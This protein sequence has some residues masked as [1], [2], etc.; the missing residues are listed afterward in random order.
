[1]FV[2][3]KG[4]LDSVLPCIL[5]DE[6]CYL[7]TE[8]IFT[9][10]LW[11]LTA[12]MHKRKDTVAFCLWAIRRTFTICSSSLSWSIIDEQSSKTPNGSSIKS[13]KGRKLSQNHFPVKVFVLFFEQ[14]SCFM[15][16][17]LKCYIKKNSVLRASMWSFQ[18]LN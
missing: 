4:S 18:I 1:M 14:F 11:N 16:L 8:V 5:T 2:L 15:S 10:Y 13:I 9:L 12:Y 7:C 17:N 6:L 3:P